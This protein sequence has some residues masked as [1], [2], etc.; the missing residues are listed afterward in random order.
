VYDGSAV[1]DDDVAEL[2]LTLNDNGCKVEGR[3]KLPAG[4]GELLTG[5][6]GKKAVPEIIT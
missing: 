3:R 6:A 4:L 1:F 5:L 2:V